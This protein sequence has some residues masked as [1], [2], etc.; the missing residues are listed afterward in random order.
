[1]TGAALLIIIPICALAVVI[2]LFEIAKALHRIA[3]EMR[4]R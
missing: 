3:D 1:M 2:P 4:R